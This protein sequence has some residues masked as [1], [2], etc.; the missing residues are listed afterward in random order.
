VLEIVS[1]KCHVSG[2]DQSKLVDLIKRFRPLN[3]DLV[4]L[5]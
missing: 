4:I 5:R 3:P 2:K 1:Q